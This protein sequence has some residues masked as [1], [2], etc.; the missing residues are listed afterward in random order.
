MRTPGVESAA[1]C[2]NV[3]ASSEGFRARSA[4]QRSGPLSRILLNRLRRQISGRRRAT[5]QPSRN[6]VNAS[7]VSA[8]SGALGCSAMAARYSGTTV[9]AVPPH[10]DRSARRAGRKMGG[11]LLAHLLRA[12]LSEHAQQS[13]SGPGMSRGTTTHCRR[14]IMGQ[15]LQVYQGQRGISGSG[16][17]DAWVPS[18][19]ISARNSAGASISECV[20]EAR[21]AHR[22]D[23]DADHR[24]RNGSLPADAVDTHD[25]KRRDHQGPGHAPITR[26]ARAPPFLAVSES[27]AFA[28]LSQEK[29]AW[30]QRYPHPAPCCPV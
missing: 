8:A 21:Q 5:N 16:G 20:P 14:R 18:R 17:A 28:P 22:R 10:E 15:S 27:S 23:P 24:T 3:S 11:D 12:I 19:A 26:R 1:S 13:G 7:I 2:P 4:R 6:G 30:G 9:V 29:H 25:R